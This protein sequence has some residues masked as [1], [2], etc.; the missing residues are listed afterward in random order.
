MT[1]ASRLWP[2]V[3]SWPPAG[4]TVRTLWAIHS[5][6]RPRRRSAGSSPRPAPRACETLPRWRGQ[7]LHE[8]ARRKFRQG[9]V[10]FGDLFSPVTENRSR[11]S[12]SQPI[13][14]ISDLGCNACGFCDSRNRRS[15]LAPPAS[16]KLRKLLAWFR[17]EQRG[18]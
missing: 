1:R 8:P 18:G 14:P 3:P 16:R 10:E 4:A 2:P 6:R 5:P 15:T 17:V 11:M 13:V 7:G 9:S 12:I